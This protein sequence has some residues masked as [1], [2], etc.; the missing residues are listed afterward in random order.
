MAGRPGVEKIE[1]TGSNRVAGRE[2]RPPADRYVKYGSTSLSAEDVIPT[3]LLNFAERVWFG[4]RLKGAEGLAVMRLM[5][6][7]NR[8]LKDGLLLTMKDATRSIGVD[9]I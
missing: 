7:V 6:A 3:L 5:I 4:G 9:H 1:F 2:E 8:A